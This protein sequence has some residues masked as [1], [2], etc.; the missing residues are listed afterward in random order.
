M[1]Y[2]LNPSNSWHVDSSNPL[3]L[4]LQVVPEPASAILLF[5]G[6]LGLLLMRKRKMV[7]K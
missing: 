6:L 2:G 7:S 3:T 1:V 5:P 4:G